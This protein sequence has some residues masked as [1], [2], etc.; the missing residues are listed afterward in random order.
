MP[1]AVA[2]NALV[3]EAIPKSVR[4]S[5]GVGSPSFRTP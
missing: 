4:S 2:V 5:T 1:I 3:F